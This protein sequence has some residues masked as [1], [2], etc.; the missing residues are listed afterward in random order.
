VI[1]STS[2]I[3]D[4]REELQR[5]HRHAREREQ[6]RRKRT[7]PGDQRKRQRE[8]RDVGAMVRLCVLTGR[9]R[10]HARGAREHH[11]DREQEEQDA[12]AHLESV[13]ADTEDAQQRRAGGG[14]HQAHG[15]RQP[16]R[17]DRHPAAPGC[18][19]AFRETCQHGQ[20]RQR[21]DDHQQHNEEFDQFVEHLRFADSAT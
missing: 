9:D 7:R 1:A 15:R 5:A 10:S 13:D 16:D 21:L 19:G 12:A 6:Y 3:T 17:L 18:V 20:H 11:F 2:R 4:L 8:D 14:E